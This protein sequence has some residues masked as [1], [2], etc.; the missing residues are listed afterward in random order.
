MEF[1]TKI[2]F[3]S[4]NALKIIAAVAMLIDH[5]G[6]LMLPQYDVLR[7]IGRLAFPIF[8]FMIAEGCKYTKNKARYF[9][10]VFGLAALCQT[11][12]YIFD[13]SLFM[14]VLVS[15]ALA[16]LM[17]YAL[18]NFK[19][20][21]FSHKSTLMQKV[22][23]ASLFAALV[24]SVYLI[25]LFVDIDYGF[26]GCM[27]PVFASFFHA[28]QNC[29]ISFL[30]KLDCVPVNVLAMALAMLPLARSI[31]WLQMYSFAALVPLMLYSGKR[32]KLKMKYF[33]YIF[34][35]LHLVILQGISILLSF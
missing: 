33:F 24:A 12:Y 19:T 8:A 27:L 16:I 9:F 35:P 25:N 5:V 2:C 20:T 22:L 11:V 4:G 28:P 7:I 32:G 31:G 34:Y 3:L 6:Y 15:F 10:T 13:K 17:V 23:S 30:Q 18:Q 1:K 14:S 26:W 29:E 21:L